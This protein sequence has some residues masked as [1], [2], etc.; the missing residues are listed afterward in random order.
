MRR[1][2]ELIFVQYRDALHFVSG[3]IETEATPLLPWPTRFPDAARTVLHAQIFGDSLLRRRVS[4]EHRVLCMMYE[5]CSR[6]LT[7]NGV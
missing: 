2:A 7:E 5:K 6:S 3:A 1:S 4:G